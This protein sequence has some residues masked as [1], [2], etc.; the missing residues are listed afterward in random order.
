MNERL[1]EL[2][3]SPAEQAMLAGEAGPAIRKAM[4]I[5]IALGKIYGAPDLVPVQS[6][7]VA[8]VSYKNLG[9]AGLEFLR[10]WAKQGARARVRTT[11]NPAGMDM[12]RWAE[13][14]IPES[15]ARQQQAVIETFGQMGI[16]PTLTCTPYYVGNRPTFGEH[17]AWSESSAVSF[18]NSV[19]G[20]RTNR[21]GGPS[22]LA[23]AF[24]GRT[25]RYGLHLDVNRRA[26]HLVDVHCAISS[27]ADVG[28]LG[29]L[30]GRLVQSGV[31]YFRNLRFDWAP[32]PAPVI[33]AHAGFQEGLTN[34]D[35]DSR[36]RGNDNIEDVLKSLGAAMAAS[37]AVGLYH[38]EGVTPE[39]GVPDILGSPRDYLCVDDLEAGYEMLNGRLEA[40]DFVSLGCPHASLEELREI[41]AWLAGKRVQALLWITAA[42]AVRDE[43]ERLGYVEQ[44]EAA[45]GHVVADTCLVVAPVE[46][47][48]VYSLATNS[49]KAA[50]YAR[51]HSGLE[52]R[53]GSTE[54]CLEAAIAGVWKGVSV[55]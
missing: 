10:T 9:D 34:Q 3:L 47:L 28:A 36:F 33:P 44:I 24:T 23:A 8:G 38:V 18:A 40:I 45:G 1:V 14:G 6:V 2:R 46:A 19:I 35:V 32:R 30:V 37:G 22:A 7:Q 13:H 52:T 29:A 55:P 12:S 15:F 27:L 39:A 5:V 17:L 20:A 4:E 25:A 42:A 41:A 26:T 49:A 51:S 11:L 43:A 21:E 48:N 54:Q 31:P 50:L 16:E 53:F